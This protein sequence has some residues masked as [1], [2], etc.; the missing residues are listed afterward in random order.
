MAR[1]VLFLAVAL[2]VLLASATGASANH[3]NGNGPNKNLVAG[4]GTTLYDG[5]MIHVNAKNDD[6][7]DQFAA[8]GHF[9]IR[10]TLDGFSFTVH[11]EVVCLNVTFPFATLVGVVTKPKQYAGSPI[12]IELFDGGEPPHDFAG[13]NFTPDCS[14]DFENVQPIQRGNYIV[15]DQSPFLFL[16]SLLPQIAEFEEAA[17]DH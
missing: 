6:P 14:F 11:G 9:Y 10:G 2:T 5:T 15:H 13:F 16:Q 1:F 3:S 12:E 7:S 4:T 17:G 8:H